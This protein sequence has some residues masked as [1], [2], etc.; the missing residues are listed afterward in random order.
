MNRRLRR[1]AQGRS[2]AATTLHVV[3]DKGP[4][5]R[6]ECVTGDTSG[7]GAEG[8]VDVARGF[9]LEAFR[10]VLHH[11]AE[12]RLHDLSLQFGLKLGSVCRPHAVQVHFESVAIVES[13][14]KPHGAVVAEVLR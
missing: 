2:T 3:V 1:R 12:A 13:L 11:R 7:N 14:P 9:S 4:A 5:R 6:R 10:P 8:L